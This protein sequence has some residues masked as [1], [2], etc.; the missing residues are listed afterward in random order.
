MS[1]ENFV[2]GEENSLSWQ[3]K[4][5]RESLLRKVGE[6]SIVNTAEALE[7]SEY[8]SLRAKKWKMHGNRR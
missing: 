2:E 8:K 4:N 6:V 7:P 5:N 3:I 1:Y